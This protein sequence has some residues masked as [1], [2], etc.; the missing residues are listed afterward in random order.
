M[1]GAEFK[2][3]IPDTGKV[4]VMGVLLEAGDCEIDSE[5][6]IIIDISEDDDDEE[7]DDDDPD[8]DDQEEGLE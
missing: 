3:L 4:Y 7:E 2:A 8:N 5:G 1:T 6:D